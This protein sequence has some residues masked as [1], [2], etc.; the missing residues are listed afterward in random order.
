MYN[1]AV[2]SYLETGTECQ[3]C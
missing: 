2:A 1:G 3:P